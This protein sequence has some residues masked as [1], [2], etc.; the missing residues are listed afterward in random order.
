MTRKELVHKLADHLGVTP[1]YLAA[2]SFAYQVGDYTVDRQGNI[3]DTRGQVVELD[4][5]LAD[6][7]E[8][9]ILEATQDTK[10]CKVLLIRL[11]LPYFWLPEETLDLR[12][13]RDHVPYDIWRQQGYLLTTEGN[14]IHYG[15]IEKFIEDLGQDYNIQ[16]IAFD[17][18]GAV[19]MVQKVLPPKKRT[20]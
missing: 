20:G 5:L 14:V 8:E 6:A 10:G 12:V 2:P 7:K 17:R 16:E 11:V 1:V 18:W 13:R 4:A 3:L 9:P 19:Q 15:F